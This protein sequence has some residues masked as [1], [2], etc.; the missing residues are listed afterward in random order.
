MARNFAKGNLHSRIVMILKVT[1]P[2]VALALLASLFLF[3]RNIDPE[4]AIP[5]AD[6]E[7]ADR[8]AQPRMT[9]AGFSTVT[10]DGATLTLS[11][12]EATPG[13]AGGT[14]TGLRGE[15]S[16]ADGFR[17]EISARLGVLDRTAGTFVLDQGV[18]IATSTGYEMTMERLTLGTARSFMESGG[19]VQATAPMGQLEAG[20]LRMDLTADGKTHL[21]VFNK[22]VRLIYQPNP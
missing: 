4:D 13:E 12:D 16:A 17:A 2:L 7:I 11:A 8:L 18:R 19:P 5:Y 15:L 14:V 10:S 6:V 21:L 20:G 9:G 22:G 3:S 1:L